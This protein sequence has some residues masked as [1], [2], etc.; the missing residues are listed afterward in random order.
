MPP[1]PCTR[2]RARGSFV[3]Q[4]WT[5]SMIHCS[6]VA[7]CCS[8]GTSEGRSWFDRRGHRSHSILCNALTCTKLQHASPQGCSRGRQVPLLS[9]AASSMAELWT[10]NLDLRSLPLTGVVHQFDRRAEHEFA[11]PELR[12]S[13]VGSGRQRPFHGRVVPS[14]PRSENVIC[15]AASR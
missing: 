11:Q 9:R 7:R 10:F 14:S 1:P 5:T 6:V 13:E 15:S 2:Q 3:E 4:G 8:T 12:N